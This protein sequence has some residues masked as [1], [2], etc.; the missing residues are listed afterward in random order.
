MASKA[1]AALLRLTEVGLEGSGCVGVFPPPSLPHPVASRGRRRRGRTK[2]GT[3]ANRVRKAL[4]RVI[5][6]FQRM[7]KIHP[8]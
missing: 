3:G 7:E 2:R 5:Y 4:W 6:V 8:I 1:I